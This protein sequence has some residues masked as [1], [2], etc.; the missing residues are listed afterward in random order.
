[1]RA[2]QVSSDMNPP[3]HPSE[4]KGNTARPLITV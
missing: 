3:E 4:L 1:M 2:S